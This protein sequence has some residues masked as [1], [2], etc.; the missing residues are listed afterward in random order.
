[1]ILIKT[2]NAKRLL[3]RMAEKAG[4]YNDYEYQPMKDEAFWQLKGMRT[5]AEVLGIRASIIWSE[6]G[7]RIAM[8]KVN[9]VIERIPH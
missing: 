8:V 9:G 1:M 7:E 3:K 4:K 2:A 5:A 6:D